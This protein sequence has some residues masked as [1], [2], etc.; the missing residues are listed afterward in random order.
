MQM[1][2][3]KGNGCQ[4][5]AGLRGPPGPLKPQQPIKLT[6]YELN[7]VMNSM[8]LC[9]MHTWDPGTLGFHY[10]CFILLLEISKGVN[11]AA[12]PKHSAINTRIA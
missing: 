3:G 12:L 5:L 10:A 7:C 8:L 6:S 11:G 9:S 2:Q 4:E 1:S